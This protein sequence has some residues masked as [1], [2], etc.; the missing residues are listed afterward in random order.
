MSKVLTPAMDADMS[1]DEDLDDC[2]GHEDDDDD[3]EDEDES[4]EEDE[5]DGEAEEQQVAVE[6]KDLPLLTIPI[7]DPEGSRFDEL[8]YWIYTNNSERWLTHF[9]PQNYESILKNIV[10]LN[11]TTPEVLAICH[12]FEQSPANEYG[13]VPQGTADEHFML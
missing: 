8:L 3:D 1:M 2:G 11:M 5:E 13:Q 9:T 4:E 7:V 10:Y 12:A 6:E